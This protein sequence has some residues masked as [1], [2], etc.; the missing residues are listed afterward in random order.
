[1]L[2]KT[3]ARLYYN[4]KTT[5]KILKQLKRLLKDINTIQN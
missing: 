2:Y 1:M 4:I 3:I 5:E